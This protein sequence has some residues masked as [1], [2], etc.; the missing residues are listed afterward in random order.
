MGYAER[1][2]KL[3]ATRGLDQTSLAERVGVSK[4][5]MSRILSGAR[6]PKLTMAYE[7]AKALGV[8]LDYLVDDS[9][10]ADPSCQLVVLTEDEWTI[11]KIVRRLGASVAIDRLIGVA[12]TDDGGQVV[13]QDTRK[14]AR[15]H[16]EHRK[17]HS[18][19]GSSHH[20]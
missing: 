7:L 18:R 15:P 3:C 17:G 6:E 12:A 11:L 4:S 13:E 19:G 20:V 9:L 16:S 8:T 10:D 1:M 5:S 14:R 2:R